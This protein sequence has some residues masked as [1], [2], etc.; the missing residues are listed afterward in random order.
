MMPSMPY[1]RLRFVMSATTSSRCRDCAHGE[2]CGGID[3]CTCIW[4]APA[5]Q[6]PVSP[7]GVA[8][9]RNLWQ[10]RIGGQH[11]PSGAGVADA[12]LELVERLASLV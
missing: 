7:A 3:G 1:A 8:R 11:Y 2:H 10:E 4:C 9:E 5:R 6:I 12:V